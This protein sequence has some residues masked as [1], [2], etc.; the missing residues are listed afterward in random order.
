VS[1][2][3]S[4]LA[5][6][7]LILSF[8]S[9]AHSQQRVKETA[10][11]DEVEA[12]RKKALDLLESL[13]SDVETLRSAENRA[14]IGSNIA[15]LLWDHDEKRARVLFA[16]AQEDLMV[17]SGA[18]LN[19]REHAHTLRVF[20]FLRSN[21]ILR[22]AKHDPQLALEFL[23]ATH[24]TTDGESPEE[25]KNDKAVEL[26]LA[27]EISKKNPQLALKLARE[28]LESGLSFDLV[29]TLEQLRATDK[30]AATN[31][32]SAIIEKLRSANFQQD[33]QALF[34]A[35]NLAGLPKPSQSDEQTTRELVGILF[36]AAQAFGCANDDTTSE[37]G[38]LR[39]RCQQLSAVFPLMEKYYGAKTAAMRQLVEQ[40]Q[41]PYGNNGI[42]AKLRELRESGT[43]EDVLALIP[44][45]P[46]MKDE[47]YASAMSRAISSDDFEKGR[48]V[49]EK[50]SLPDRKRDMLNYIEQMEK[51]RSTSP[52]R[53]AEV[54][55]T[56]AG[57]K[58]NEERL[59]FLFDVARGLDRER[60]SKIILS[61]L[62]QM[63][64]IMGTVKP[65]REQ[66]G[67]QII[68]ALLFSEMKSDRGF[69][70]MESIVPKL[71][72]LV[73]AAASLDG[74]DNNYLRD[75]EW[76]MKGEGTLGSML[77]RLSESAGYFAWLDFDRAQ[78]L[79]RQFERPELRLMAQSKLAQAIL[80]GKAKNSSNFH[81]GP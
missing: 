63:T 77:T 17:L 60:D 50:I 35:V 15:E 36:K 81:G 55:R 62:N 67:G 40:Y 32:Y 12:L 31:L 16:K 73:A 27:R 61:I 10:N 44:Q 19:E 64:D 13:A 8:S 47:I 4:L 23:R 1:H 9:P 6:L 72:E 11:S 21:I 70:I 3:F 59:R 71:N 25:L 56:V 46:E 41:G 34:I 30:D 49:V 52:E 24:P 79:A 18:D 39:Y 57:L 69:R 7:V 75:G 29:A 78:N 2:R 45:N 5:V 20:A 65:G 43:V 80:E 26:Q 58:N 76:A 37:D 53:L 48:A 38:E 66:L 42:Y 22:I 68:L 14:R 74:I 54:Q 28:S 51:R 33:Y